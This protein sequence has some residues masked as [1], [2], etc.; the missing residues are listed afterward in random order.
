MRVNDR[1]LKSPRTPVSRRKPTLET[2]SDPAF[3]TPA[4]ADDSSARLESA[5]P[6]GCAPVATAAP[7]SAH[8]WETDGNASRSS[9]TTDARRPRT[10]GLLDPGLGSRLHSTRSGWTVSLL[11]AADHDVSDVTIQA[12]I[13]CSS[14]ASAD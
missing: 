3:I 5:T 9:E 10:G 8:P 1:L 14:N 4:H 2:G 12:G 11:W 13:S 7:A 6:T